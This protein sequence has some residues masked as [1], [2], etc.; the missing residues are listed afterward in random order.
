MLDHGDHPFPAHHV[1]LQL[2]DNGLPGLPL[3]KPRNENGVPGN[4]LLT[5][6]R[7]TQGD[8]RLPG[9]TLHRHDLP[10]SH[11]PPKSSGNGKADLHDIIG[12]VA[13]QDRL[14]VHRYHFV[15]GGPECK[16]LFLQRRGGDRHRPVCAYVGRGCQYGHVLSP[17]QFHFLPIP[18][19]KSPWFPRR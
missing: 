4:L 19:R 11:F 5:G 9:N 6:G 1:L 16:A 7:S 3:V 10:P 15:G 14:P 18:D 2:A 17:F 13:D 12:H 8:P